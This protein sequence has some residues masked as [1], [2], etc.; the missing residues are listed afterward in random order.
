MY[1]LNFQTKRGVV[2]FFNVCNQEQKEIEKQ[3][4]GVSERKRDKVL[5]NLDKGSFLDKLKENV[6][7]DEEMNKTN[8]ANKPTWSVLRDDFVLG[9]KMKDWEKESD[10]GEDE[11]ADGGNK[12][13][14]KFKNKKFKK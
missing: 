4:T 5:S 2:K 6:D 14:N 12:K 10:D 3:T 7:S 13:D 11:E 8:D 1:F 9:A